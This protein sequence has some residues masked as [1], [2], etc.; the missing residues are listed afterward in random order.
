MALDFGLVLL[1]AGV[2]W[3]AVSV[4]RLPGVWR[5]RR[6]FAPRRRGGCLD[7]RRRGGGGAGA[8]PTIRRGQSR[9]S[10]SPSPPPVPVRSRCP[11][12]GGARG[13]RPQSARLVA[14]FLALLVAGAGDVSVAARVHDRRQGA[15]D[16]DPV[17]ARWRRVSAQ[18]LQD[19]LYATLDQIDAHPTC[20]ELVGAREDATAPDPDRA[21]ARLVADR[22]A[23]YRLTSAVELYGAERAAREPVRAQPPG[24]R[25]R[26]VTSRRMRLGRRSTKCRRSGRASATC[27]ARAAAICDGRDASS[28]ASSCA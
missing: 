19:A 3:S 4:T 24:V 21:F 8:S 22:A 10:S 7:R 18:D 14:L 28:A 12:S 16:R 9:R 27:C 15:A 11:R 6:A 20:A 5:T 13:G 25:D 26:R 2:I 1:H 23:T 17:R